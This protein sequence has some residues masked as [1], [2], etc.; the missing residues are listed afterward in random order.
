[1]YTA[2]SKLISKPKYFKMAF[3]HS[4]QAA[5]PP[6]EPIDIQRGAWSR[7]KDMIEDL[8]ISQDLKLN[9]IKV[10]MERMHGFKARY[11]LDVLRLCLSLTYPASMPQYRR[12]CMIGI[13]RRT[14][15]PPSG[16]LLAEASQDDISHQMMPLSIPTDELWI[17]KD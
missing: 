16:K 17:V 14:K 10:E 8:Y 9:S 3:Q 4:H 15:S 7:F 6:C 12:N 1:V 5:V 2:S 13:L 11:N